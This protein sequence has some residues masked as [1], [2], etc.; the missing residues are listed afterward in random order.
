MSNIAQD[1]T[2]RIIAAL[3]KGDLPWVRQWSTSGPPTRQDTGKAYRGINLF[4]L[5]ISRAENDWDSN[6]W[7]TFKQAKTRGGFVRKGER[8]TPI[9]KWIFKDK[10][11][12]VP[13]TGEE[14]RVRA[15][16]GFLVKF[17]VFNRDQ[18]DGLPEAP[19]KVQQSPVVR[20][21]EADRVIN[22]TGA[23][24]S[25]GGD[26]AYYRPSEDRIQVPRPE[27]FLNRDAY[28]ST[29]THEL[30]HWSGAPH[31]LDRQF[32][33]RVGDKEAYAFEELL[34][35]LGA[36]FLCAN[37]GIDGHSDVYRATDK[38]AA[39]IQ[40]WLKVLKANNKAIFTASSKAQAA[41]DYLLAFSA[42][43]QAAA[44]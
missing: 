40:S 16:R 34:A 24:I 20:H 22:A 25:H 8:G 3:E 4:L 11:E 18:I 29:L 21:A 15:T 9:I 31:R 27:N 14:V 41:T 39:Y 30:T 10:T 12:T 23:S 17:T 19:E 43:E 6:E 2:D 38:H 42:S 13:V 5:G 28:Y 26:R 37:I 35:E 1:V 32:G 33:N 44:A 7:Y 36:A